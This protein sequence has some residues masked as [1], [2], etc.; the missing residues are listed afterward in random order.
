MTHVTGAQRF[1]TGGASSAGRGRSLL[2]GAALTQ[3]DSLAT[4]RRAGAR[5]LAGRGRRRAGFPESGRRLRLTRN[6][7]RAGTNFTDASWKHARG[8]EPCAFDDPLS[9]APL[10]APRG[11]IFPRRSPMD[12]PAG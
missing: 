4:P 10:G 5:A 9:L 7:R 2:G 11:A 8:I 6:S 12:S 1:L 3:R